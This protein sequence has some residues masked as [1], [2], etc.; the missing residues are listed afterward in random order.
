[1]P[2][3]ISLHEAIEAFHEHAIFHPD[4]EQAEK[5]LNVAQF[6]RVL[7]ELLTDKEL[8]SQLDSR[9]SADRL[10]SL[11]AV[12]LASR[13][14]LVQEMTPPKSRQAMAPGRPTGRG[15]GDARH[16]MSPLMEQDTSRANNLDRRMADQHAAPEG[17]AAAYGMDYNQRG[18]ARG[19]ALSRES[20]LA[21]EQ[22]HITE[23]QRID[24]L[25]R[26][27]LP[28]AC[29]HTGADACWRTRVGAC[30][31]RA[32][33]EVWRAAAPRPR[34]RRSS[35]PAAPTPLPPCPRAMPATARPRTTPPRCKVSSIWRASETP[36]SSNCR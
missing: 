33:N 10:S 11:D 29:T 30:C 36:G 24:G 12:R 2:Q 26:R 4:A 16:R 8:G 14:Q 3:V 34:V 6:Q 23:D 19:T 5:T 13:E 1:M 9:D 31:E 17:S 21:E 20:V 32:T 7:Q 15:P 22:P 35:R 28:L 25:Q 18:R 27:C